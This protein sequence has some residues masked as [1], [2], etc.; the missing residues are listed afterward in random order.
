MDKSVIKSLSWPWVNGFA[1]G[2][3]GPESLKVLPSLSLSSTGWVKMS[4]VSK[5]EKTEIAISL[6]WYV[7]ITPRV[8]YM[9]IPASHV[10]H[11]EIAITV[12]ISSV[13]NKF[14]EQERADWTSIAGNY[15]SHKE[16]GTTVKFYSIN[17]RSCGNNRITSVRHKI[18]RRKRNDRQPEHVR[19]PR[20][21]TKKKESRKSP[22]ARSATKY[23][24]RHHELGRC[25]RLCKS[26]HCT[27]H[28]DENNGQMAGKA[29]WSTSYHEKTKINIS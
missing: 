18:Q 12:M 19:P 3:A 25:T 26:E 2:V 23:C 10:R 11:T 20:R 14:L 15:G 1:F 21:S 13:G 9:L 7:G 5:K 4:S 6:Q 8:L 27:R 22:T 17:L 29:R 16:E 28:M 24:T